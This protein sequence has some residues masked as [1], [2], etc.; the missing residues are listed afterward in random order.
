MPNT[1]KIPLLLL[2][3]A[4][5]LAAATGNAQSATPV[6]KVN[7]VVIPQSWVDLLVAN[8][9]ARGQPDSPEI[10]GRFRED[11]IT[12]ELI[13]QE[14]TKKGLNKNAD[15]TAQ[16]EIQRHLILAN[17]YFQDYF[18]TN[19]IS[20]DALKNEYE[21]QKTQAPDK[22]Y[23]ARHILVKDE[24]EAKQITAQL[25]KGALFDKIAAEKSEDQ[26]SKGQGGDLGWGPP[27]RY[28]LPFAEALKKLKKGQLTDPP[29]QTQYG[30]HVIRLDDERAF[31][32]PSLEQ[33]K[34]QVQQQLQQQVI[35]KIISDLR[36]KAKI[37]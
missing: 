30:W 36:A 27:G 26:G 31:K 32:V 6:A 11:L 5:L 35:A 34:P 1:T 18:K 16:L 28:V 15:V 2:V 7:G 12:Q 10:R 3:L 29:V 24:A 25:K 9:T 33:V 4:G 22:E 21:R 37:E 19:P 17:A 14:A 13:T 8:A 23:K 20:E